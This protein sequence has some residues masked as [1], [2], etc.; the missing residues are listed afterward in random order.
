MEDIFIKILNM[1]ITASYLA[2]AVILLKGIFRKMPKWISCILWG[3]VGLRL[4]LPFSFESILSLIPSTETVPSD[5]MLSPEPH[6]SSGIEAFNSAVNPIIYENFAPEPFMSANP[7]QIIIFIASV[8]W[9]TGIICM[10]IYTGVS[11]L[12]LKRKTAERLKTENGTFVCDKIDSPFILGVIRPEIYIPSDT[13]EDALSFITAHERA[14][15]KRG[16]HLWKPLGF[17]LLSVHW[18]NP[19]MWIAYIFLCRDIEAACDEK[20]LKEMGTDV[21]KSY[22]N[23]LISCSSPRKLI[24]ACPLAF[25]ETAVRSRIKNILNYK[26]PTLWIIIIALI[27]GIILSVCFLT[28]P[29]TSSDNQ[30]ITETSYDGVYLTVDAIFKNADGDFVFDIKWHNETDHQVTYGEMYAINYIEN[31]RNV[32]LNSERE[33]ITIGYLLE[34]HSTANKQY[35]LSNIDLSKPGRYSFSTSFH[36]PHQTGYTAFFEF[37]LTEEMTIEGQEL[38]DISI[39]GGADGPEAVLTS[40]QM[41][42]EDVIRISEMSEAL[43]WDDFEG[44]DYITASFG[45]YSR[46]YKI[47]DMFT[48]RVIALKEGDPIDSAILIAND[49]E[50]SAINIQKDDVEAFIEAHKNNPV[51]RNISYS[52]AVIPINYNQ[53]TDSYMIKV[54][55]IPKYAALSSV[56]ALTCVR[57]KDTEKL[58]EFITV[59]DSVTKPLYGETLNYH[60]S[61]YDGD[62][63]ESSELI[64]IHAPPTYTGSNLGCEYAGVYEAEKTLSI[65]LREYTS[66]E[67]AGNE[68][69]DAFFYLF[70]IPADQI[71]NI[72][73]VSVIMSSTVYPKGT[74]TDEKPEYIYT[75]EDSSQDI[76]KPHFMLYKDGRFVFNFSPLSSFYAVGT[77]T[78]QGNH[79]ILTTDD[80]KYTYRFIKNNGSLIFDGEYSSEQRFY[81]DLVDRAVFTR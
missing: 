81:S 52:T 8:L 18:F 43:D 70:E 71:M 10:L 50:A 75:Y 1:S 3:L 32:L 29:N 74:I 77:Y 27:A 25:G 30:F 33:F 28:D 2:V 20:V 9:V 57:I 58:S 42:L 47:S 41:T 12:V 46:E 78:H 40:K 48:L 63:F 34:P 72:E 59:M 62:F 36:L 44:Y 53:N 56:R 14:H 6:I 24:T 45:V 21:K 49:S 60:L 68:Q 79:L 55:G 13:P 23:A 38:R 15:I 65:G 16:D 17:L 19:L 64:I 5:I 61:T 76:F 4:I 7:L 37:T 54:G 39:I 69:R 35:T 26:K 51:V 66:G 22:S 31:G 11:Y 73:E 80:G 67:I